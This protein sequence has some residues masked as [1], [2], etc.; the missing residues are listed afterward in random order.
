MATDKQDSLIFYKSEDG[1]IQLNVKLEKDTVWLTQSQMSNLFG[2]D[3]TVIVRHIRNIY[4][5]A[6]LYEDATCAK[7]AQV[8]EEGGRTVRRTIP[9][10]NLD[11]I[12]SVG[13]RVNSKNATQ[14]RIWATS[15]LKQYLIKGYAIN[16]QRLQQLGEVIRIMKRTQ[17]ELDAKQV[18]SV[19]ENYNTALTLL[20]DYDHQCMKRPEGSK[21]T[22]VLSYEECRNLIDQMRFN[23]DSDLFG[24]EKDDSF[25]GSIGNIY[26]SF[27][28]EDVYPSLEE[29]AANLL[30]FVTKNH[31]FSDGNKRIA[32]TVFLYFLD[33]NGILYDEN[34]NKRIADY[35]L[36]ALT[37]M[38]AESRTE[39]KEMMVSII[40]NCI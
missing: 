36:V 32:A 30:Y 6:E 15:I 39:E 7:N 38:I 31:S 37:I 5:S 1:N 16:D 25:K 18:L 24:H 27:G 2:V 9:Y 13:Y 10:Y 23:A 14:F 22:Y 4:K 35:T 29:K 3:R 20:D 12:I 11:M 8:Q 21:A 33:K 34:G 28:G 40:M 26:Q 17:N 19:I